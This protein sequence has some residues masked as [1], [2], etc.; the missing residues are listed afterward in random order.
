MGDFGRLMGM[1]SFREEYHLENVN[2]E[3][4]GRNI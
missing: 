3:M 2:D 1:Q 4:I